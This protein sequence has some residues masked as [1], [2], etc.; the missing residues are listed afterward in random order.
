[1]TYSVALSDTT[2]AVKAE[3][4]GWILKKKRKRMQGKK[5]K[6]KKKNII[7]DVG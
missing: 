3:V 5:K 2:H 7:H 1:L 4:C 6:K